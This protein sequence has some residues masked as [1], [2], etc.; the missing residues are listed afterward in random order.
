[1]AKLEIM[2]I[3][4]AQP[5]KAT[6]ENLPEPTAE[7]AKPKPTAKTAKA[8]QPKPTAEK[9][10][11]AQAEQPE[12]ASKKKKSKNTKKQHLA[13]LTYQALAHVA[14]EICF[15]DDSNRSYI[16]TPDGAELRIRAVGTG[17]AGLHIC[18]R[19]SKGE[20]SGVFSLWPC[21]E[22]SGYTCAGV[23]DIKEGHEDYLTLIGKFQGVQDEKLLI[24]MGRNFGDRKVR[25]NVAVQL[26]TALPDWTEQQQV[27]IVAARSGAGWV[28]NGRLADSER[29]GDSL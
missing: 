2:A 28:W 9:A 17:T 26:N 23:A 16:K 7:K 18:R 11:P 15:D 1:M 14:G 12:Q 5:K 21:S 4:K 29:L 13:K 27:A 19:F 10:Q 24:G 3:R 25:Y 20:T 6:V 8:K 22:K